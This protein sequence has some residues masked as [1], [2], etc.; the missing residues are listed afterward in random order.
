MTDQS[1]SGLSAAEEA[2]F[3]SGGETE[4][5]AEPAPVA[6]LAPTADTV[7]P[8]DPS[9]AVV[10]PA[11][12]QERDD[13]GRFVP[14]QALHAEREEHKKTKA[15][16]EQIRQQ[17]A[18]LNDRWNTLLTATKQPEQQADTPPN[19]EEDIFA[20]AK[21]QGDQ[22]KSLQEKIDSRDKAQEQA[23]AVTQA[24]NELW[25]HWSQSAQAYAATNT[26]FG[27]A[28]RFLSDTR[29]AQLKAMA[30]VDPNFA[31]DQGVLNQINMELKSIVGAARQKGIDPAMAVHELAKAY[32][33]AGAKPAPTPDPAAADLA[34]KI[35]QL[36]AAQNASRTLAASPGQNAGDPMSP[37]AIAAMPAKEFEAW[38]KVPENASR[39]QKMMGG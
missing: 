31:S 28:V 19:P 4:I 1:T 27:D 34:G 25:G 35:S 37:E 16:L 13:K 26:D 32:G 36:D 7:D 24:D 23:A 33:F 22:L 20:Y 29:T 3:S 14:H 18:I 30:L 8:V 9:A 5:T 17:Q 6:D 38:M 10:D 12:P 11:A 15:E 39:F 21:W 2:Y